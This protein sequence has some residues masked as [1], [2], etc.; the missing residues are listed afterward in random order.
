MKKIICILSVF[1][2]LAGYTQSEYKAKFSTPMS[3]N[4]SVKAKVWGAAEPNTLLYSDGTYA[5]FLRFDFEAKNKTKKLAIIERYGKDLKPEKV[6]ETA[7]VCPDKTEALPYKAFYLKGKIIIMYIV[8]VGKNIHD[9]YG[10]TM[11]LQG[12]ASAPILLEAKASVT[13]ATV[14]YVITDDTSKLIAYK[15]NSDNGFGY[16]GAIPVK[17]YDNELNVL[18]D[19]TAATNKNLTDVEIS[20]ICFS[21]AGNMYFLA[22]KYKEGV[23]EL[24]YDYSL[25]AVTK[26]LEKCKEL[27]L[28]FENGFCPR[29]ATLKVWN[30]ENILIEGYLEKKEGQVSG[31]FHASVN[32]T[33]MKYNFLNAGKFSADM[34]RK[35]FEE[36]DP[37]RKGN[38]VV[39]LPEISTILGRNDGGY[40]VVRVTETNP[41][42]LV[43]I[44]S[45]DNRGNEEWNTILTAGWIYPLG[46][47][48][49]I[50]PSNDK[51]YVFYKDIKSNVN[52]TLRKQTVAFKEPEAS[53]AMA[54]ISDKG[55]LTKQLVHTPS[56]S[57]DDVNAFYKINK[58]VSFQEGEFIFQKY[59]NKTFMTGKLIV[60]Q[61]KYYF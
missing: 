19:V 33:T 26:S 14:D 42:D 61:C 13:W 32:A 44:T 18:L 58:T 29:N 23:K 49:T 35:I 37:S 10:L 20:N 24:L 28:V 50:I 21:D 9:L 54:I 34:E 48:F 36:V 51:L 5:Y 3:N 1:I 45:I 7:L 30:D 11:T 31:I 57:L 60:K 6:A 4:S 22:S 17:V 46:N 56:T 38:L 43:V 39:R 8:E 55:V 40:T 25:Y 2:S 41:S 12:K 27:P 59:S 16:R 15:K 47:R 52:T 53:L